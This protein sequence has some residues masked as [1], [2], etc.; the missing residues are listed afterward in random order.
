MITAFHETILH[1]RKKQ[2]ILKG[3]HTSHTFFQRQRRLLRPHSGMQAFISPQ[4]SGLFFFHTNLSN[5]G[6]V[7][8]EIS[9]VL[10]KPRIHLSLLHSSF[11]L[12]HFGL[13]CSPRSNTFGL[14]FLVCVQAS[15]SSPCSNTFGLWSLICL[16]ASVSS[17]VF[18][19]RLNCSSLLV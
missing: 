2:S 14:W 5:N 1:F 3:F 17:P 6:T 11:C 12:T 18:Q 7:G 8:M 10:F 13:V 4:L 9:V 19:T 15:I 16:Q